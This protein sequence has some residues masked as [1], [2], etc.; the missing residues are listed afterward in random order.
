MARQS[1]MQHEVKSVRAG[2]VDYNNGNEVT[3]EITTHDG[4]ISLTLFGL[5]SDSAAHISRVLSP[6]N[7]SLTEEQIRADE[8]KKIAQ[9]IGVDI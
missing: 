2:K 9:R 1:I 8:R 4:E 5:P 7:M 6:F 3:L